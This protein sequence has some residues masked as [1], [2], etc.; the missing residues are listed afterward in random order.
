MLASICIGII[1]LS[2]I[3]VREE[4]KLVNEN[5]KVA[6]AHYSAML[7]KATDLTCFPRTS[8]ADG[9]FKCVAIDD[10]TSGFWAGNLW[11]MYE[12]TKEQKWKLAAEK[13]TDALKDNQF[14][15]SHHDIG[16][17]MYC[18]YGNGYRLTKNAVY[19]DILIQS[20]KSAIKRFDPKVG[21]IKSWNTRKSIGKKNDWEYP[22][23]IDNMMNLE[24]LF[25]A[26]KVTGDDVYKN[27]ALSHAEKTRK[28]HIREDFSVYHVVNYDKNNGNALHQQ[29]AQGF[30]DNSTWARGQAWGIYG[31]TVMYRETKDPKYLT[32]AKNLADFYINH[33]NLPK[34]QIP[35]WDFNAGQVGYVPDWA[36]HPDKF[37]VQPRDAS[38]AAIV[39]SALIELSG[40]VKGK[41][42]L[43][44]LS[45]AKKIIS[46][47]SS[48]AYRAKPNTNNDFL[49]MHSV[50]NLPGSNE[51]DV[52]LV[53]ADYY[54]LEALS[55]LKKLD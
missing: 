54:F 11:Y 40:Y 8:Y 9:R 2:N 20:A 5:F 27:V 29:T 50:G 37:K 39:S 18:S 41:E 34:D 21:V 52:P 31:F 35:Y 55:R 26:S 7:T 19:K 32:T 16:F 23:I 22:V 51:I 42:R 43:R 30:S 1:C 25:F 6:A 28:N 36:Y 53:Y 12:Q 4:S 46:S 38:A 14:L 45:V 49:L 48:N 15:T 13:W 47:L 24:L 3:S 17:M 10:W 44:Y 33:P